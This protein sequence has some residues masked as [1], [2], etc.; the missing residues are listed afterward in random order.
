MRTLLH[1]THIQAPAATVWH[2]LTATDRYPQW[3]PFM[4]SLSGALCVGQRLTVTMRAGKRTMTF[5]P[6][7]QAFEPGTLLRWRGRLAVPGLFDG[8]HELRV[9][10]TGSGTCQFTQRETFR[11]ILVPVMRGLLDDTDTAFAAMNT[12][13]QARAAAPSGLASA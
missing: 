11:G 10:S 1:T 6:T 9:E 12:A 13:L 3:N 8:E 5:H 7:V 2:I 4:L